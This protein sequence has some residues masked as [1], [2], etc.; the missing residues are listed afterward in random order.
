[1]SKEEPL[2]AVVQT[3]LEA[4]GSPR[5]GR[6]LAVTGTGRLQLLAARHA[7]KLVDRV[8]ARQIRR[9]VASGAFDGAD[10]AAGLRQRHGR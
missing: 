3:L 6:D 8:V 7:P 4:C 10:I 9:R 1:M 5:P 2:E